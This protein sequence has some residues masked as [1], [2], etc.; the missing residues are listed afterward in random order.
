MPERMTIREWAVAQNPPISYQRA[1]RWVKNEQ[2]PACV[3]VIREGGRYFVIEHP[4]R[5]VVSPLN[6]FKIDS[7][8]AQWLMTTAA[9]EH[10]DI[11]DL[12][13]RTL[14]EGK[15]GRVKVSKRRL[16][17]RVDEL[18]A[19]M[20]AVQS[21]IQTLLDSRSEVRSENSRC[22]EN[23]DMRLTVE[24]RKS[25]EPVG[26]TTWAADNNVPYSTAWRWARS[27]RLETYRTD[28]QI[29]V[30]EQTPD[31]T[32]S[33]KRLTD[34]ARECN[35]PYAT[36]W[37]WYRNKQ[38]PFRAA[39]V[40][41]AVFVEPPK[42]VTYKR[43]RDW[44]KTQDVSYKDA[45]RLIK[46]GL[47]PNAVQVGYSILVAETATVSPKLAEHA[48]VVA[49]VPAPLTPTLE[50]YCKKR[51]VSAPRAIV[52]LLEQGLAAWRRTTDDYI[53]A[54]EIFGPAA[55][56]PATHAGFP[57]MPFES[58]PMAVPDPNAPLPTFKGSDYIDMNP[59]HDPYNPPL[60]TEFVPFLREDPPA[61]DP[62]YILFGP[63]PTS[64]EVYNQQPKREYA[65]YPTDYDSL[66]DARDP[67]DP[68]RKPVVPS[69][70]APA[71][72]NTLDNTPTDKS[73]LSNIPEEFE[74]VMP[75]TGRIEEVDPDPPTPEE[76]MLARLSAYIIMERRL[77]PASEL[78]ATSYDDPDA[79]NTLLNI[80]ATGDLLR[81]L[82]KLVG[83]GY[84]TQADIDALEAKGYAK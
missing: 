47:L 57:C 82:K 3:E 55:V 79:Q 71:P 72:D 28:H 76:R 43:L 80:V 7:D 13:N 81:E 69:T 24:S 20:R 60:K 6:G 19:T 35:V 48:R 41:E 58:P 38:L 8:L 84:I 29:F 32:V 64:E 44:I 45:R 67:N 46:K 61:E 63:P 17:T 51:H 74:F 18:H 40:G 73:A 30:R 2:M 31:G 53:S 12:F 70:P 21:G 62:D 75:Y 4:E 66:A 26:L 39:T 15:D 23:A 59:T 9:M 56:A 5:L 16:G 33:R 83:N 34:W 27:G 65:L 10:C 1:W 78:C 77:M 68:R 11:H 37:R 25:E 36:A 22:S 54:E 42:G 49:Y 14:R 52:D 50:S